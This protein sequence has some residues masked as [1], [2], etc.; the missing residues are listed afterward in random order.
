MTIPFEWGSSCV[1]ATYGSTYAVGTEISVIN[2]AYYWPVW[3][4][5]FKAEGRAGCYTN[6]GECA[7]SF[8]SPP[9]VTG[10]PNYNVLHTD[11]TSYS[12]VYSCSDLLG[13][14]MKNEYVWVLSRTPYLPAAKY[15]EAVTVMTEKIPDY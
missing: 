5:P 12:V 9:D 7:V 3:F 11:Y 13:G 15:E 6:D 2:R 10:T 14:A 8:R 4:L 1:T